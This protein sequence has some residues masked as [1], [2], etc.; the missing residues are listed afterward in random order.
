[1]TQPFSREFSAPAPTAPPPAPPTGERRTVSARPEPLLPPREKASKRVRTL[2]ILVVILSITTLLFG[3]MALW[4]QA[5]PIRTSATR[6]AAQA[7]SEDDIV[8]VAKRFTENLTTFDY[9]TAQADF[10][11]ILELTTDG[12]ASQ[13]SS[14]LKGD[15][16]SYRKRVQDQQASSTGEVKSVSV[17]SRDNDTATVLVFATQ[18]VRNRQQPQPRTQV[19]LLELTLV[20]DG[21]DWK[22]DNVGNPSTNPA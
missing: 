1:V 2:T 4:P 10:E 5:A 22:V 17:S 14:A 16:N 3:L 12:F 20:R 7:Q 18:T 15:I 9:K 11:E 6:A 13:F 8:D 19:A 21:D